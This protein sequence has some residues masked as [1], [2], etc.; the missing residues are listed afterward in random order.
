MFDTHIHR[1]AA[2]YPQTITRH[3]HRAPTDES[4]RL[5]KEMQDKAQEAMI[6]AFRTE[7]NGFKLVTHVYPDHLRNVLNLRLRFT[8][9]ETEIDR[10]IELPNSAESMNRDEWLKRIRDEVAKAIAGYIVLHVTRDGI[11]CCKLDGFNA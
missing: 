11:A 4:V 5:L 7:A 2:P 3:E 8:L 9:N 10:T 6:L 1:T